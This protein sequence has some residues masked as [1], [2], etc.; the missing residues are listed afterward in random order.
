MIRQASIDAFKKA[1]EDLEET[2]IYN[3][4]EKAKKLAK[5][6]INDMLSNADMNSIV[7]SDKKNGLIYIGG[8]RADIGQ[9]TNL[10]SE[11]DFLASS[12]IWKLIYE[13]PKELAQRSMFVSG[14]TLADM[15]KGKS[16]LYA[17]SVQNN[18]LELFKSYKQK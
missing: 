4:D 15:Q 13:T 12:T 10:K 6:M 2:N 11:A 16:I 7:T 1:S 17:L 5:K 8:N 9:L 18:I 3:T 14:E